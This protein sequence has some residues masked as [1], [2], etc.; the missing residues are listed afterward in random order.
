MKEYMDQ[1]KEIENEVQKLMV[2]LDIKKLN[3]P[4]SPDTINTFSVDRL[5]NLATMRF[6]EINLKEVLNMTSK[7][8]Q[9]Y[10]NETYEY[11]EQTKNSTTLSKSTLKKKTVKHQLFHLGVRK[12]S[13]LTPHESLNLLK[14]A[15]KLVG[16]YD[17]HKA[18]I[19]TIE[20]EY[21]TKFS[22][23]IACTYLSMYNKEEFNEIFTSLPNPELYTKWSNFLFKLSSEKRIFN[24]ELVSEIYKK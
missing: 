17:Q 8:F 15:V 4:S 7:G 11:K 1:L 5:L 6:A 20:A 16:L 22:P 21:T 18:L 9:L 23:Y 13:K 24:E 19:A 3:H 2:E 12:M 10:G 14:K